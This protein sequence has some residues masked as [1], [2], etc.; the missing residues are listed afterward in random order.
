[1]SR[2]IGF[3]LSGC[4]V[5]DGAEIHESVISMLALQR[6]GHHLVYMAPDVPLAHVVDHQTGA[7]ATGMSR[8]VLIESA[9]IARGPVRD[10]ATVGVDEVDGLFFPGG[11][12]AAKNLCNF[13]FAGAKAT[14]QPDVAR[15]IRACHAAGKPMAFLC[16]A[17]VIPALLFPGIEVTIGT[18][19]D[20]AAAINAMG[21]RH[22][23]L[24]VDKAHT[25]KAHRVVTSPAYMLAA[26]TVEVE[27]SVAA[28]VHQFEALF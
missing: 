13:A 11:F 10:I 12:G 6:R 16:I 4:G 7:E 25:D 5:Y 17:P 1:M 14:V 20:T 22:V 2:R 21:A 27:A 24:P 26:N 19:P 8:R 15:L 23:A 3:V 9:R 28:A 18:D